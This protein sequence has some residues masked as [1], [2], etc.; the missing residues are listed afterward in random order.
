MRSDRLAAG[1]GILAA[2][3]FAAGFV[4]V[5]LD[6]PTSDA[7]RSDVLATYTDD[8]TNSRQALGVLLTGLGAIC[9]LPFLGYIHRVLGN[10]A[11]KG[12]VLPATALAGG[13]VLVGGLFTGAVLSSAVSAGAYFDAQQVDADLAMTT[14]AAGFYLHGFAAMAGGVLIAAVAIVARQAALL[15]RWLTVL[16]FVVAVASIPA[17]VLG[18]WILAEALWIAAAAALIARPAASQAAGGVRMEGAASAHG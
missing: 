7:T 15:P 4:L 10:R 1:A 13:I 14:V 6:A 16:G 18:M 11:G 9:F 2:A 3:L 5:G 8:A 17:A 12:S